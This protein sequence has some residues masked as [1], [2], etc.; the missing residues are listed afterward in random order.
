M[1][2]P[3]TNSTKEDS[4]WVNELNMQYV[5]GGVLNLLLGVAALGAMGLGIWLVRR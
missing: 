1:E 2:F 4:G 3:R 5:K